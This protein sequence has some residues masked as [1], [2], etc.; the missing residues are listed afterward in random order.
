MSAKIYRMI[1]LLDVM[2]V[3]NAKQ[4]YFVEHFKEIQQRFIEFIKLPL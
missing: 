3:F 1:L 2:E 4:P